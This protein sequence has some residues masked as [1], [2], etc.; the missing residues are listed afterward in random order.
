M[1]LRYSFTL[2]GLAVFA[3]ACSVTPSKTDELCQKI[4]DFANASA[5]GEFHTVRLTTDWGGVFTKSDDPNDVLIAAKSCQHDED[6]AGKALCGY[7]VENSSTEFAGINYRRALSCV[8]VA[9]SGLSPTD[10][11]RLPPIAISRAVSGKRVRSEVT[12]EFAEGTNSAPP[13]LSISAG[14]TPPVPKR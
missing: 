12:I 3:S 8:R 4:A 9:S 13:M 14:R 6:D 10:D 5:S 11:D 7:L 2:V 1:Q